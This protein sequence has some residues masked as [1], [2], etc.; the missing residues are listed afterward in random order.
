[1]IHIDEN[2]KLID[3]NLQIFSMVWNDLLTLE[4]RVK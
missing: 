3:I 1:M 2:K 4:A